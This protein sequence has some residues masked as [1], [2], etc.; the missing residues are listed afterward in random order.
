MT[1]RSGVVLL[2]A[3]A[4]FGLRLRVPLIAAPIAVDLAW[5]LRKR[6]DDDAQ[7]F[8]FHVGLSF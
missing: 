7:V 6:R 5:P 1:P 4:G 2:G 3:V 8:S